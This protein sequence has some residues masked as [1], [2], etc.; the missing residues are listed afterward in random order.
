[1]LVKMKEYFQGAETSG[2]LLE[3]GQAYDLDAPLAEWLVKTKKA[4][5]VKPPSAPKPE[6]EPMPELE[7]EPSPEPE[8]VRIPA[9]KARYKGAKR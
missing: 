4:E 3:P 5:V 9:Y 6:P 2:K 7:P 1:M 8:P